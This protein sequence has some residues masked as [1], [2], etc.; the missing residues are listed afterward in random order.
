[1][2][3]R[4]G[5]KDLILYVFVTLLLILVL[6]AM[7]QFDR[8]FKEVQEIKR[9]NNDLTRDIV[10]IQRKLESGIITSGSAGAAEQAPEKLATFAPL[11]AAQAMSGYAP[12]DWLI[13]NFGTK[14]GR[15]T[16]LVASDLYQQ[17]VE[18][19]V[20][21]SLLVRSA[22]DLEFQPLL[23]T[24][25]EVKDNTEQWKKY[26]QPLKAKGLAPDKISEEVRK[27][28]K[29]PLA[30]EI[31]FKLRRG[32]QFSDGTP[33]TSD[34]VVFTFE[35]IMNEA[36][37]A[38]RAR[39]Y[40]GGLKK[41]EALGPYEVTFKFADPYFQL[42]DLIGSTAIMSKKFY[43]RFTP[44]QFNDHIGLMIGTG[45]YKLQNPESWN[46]G[47]GVELVRNERYWGVP[48]ALDRLIWR[49]I[50]DESAEMVMLG[51]GEL[52]I[53]AC[54]PEQY[55]KLL[56]DQRVMKMARPFKYENPLGGYTYI[57]WNQRKKI[58]EGK[59]VATP[60]A[61]KR[62]RQAMT[63]LVDRE[64]IVKDVYLGYART[65]SGPFN[66]DTPQA[67][68]SIKPWP[69]DETKAK[70]VL[71]ELGFKDKNND[72]VLE[73]PDGKPFSFKLSFPSGS[74]TTQRVVLFL[75]DSFARA[76]I[77]LEPDPL[78]WPVLLDRLKQS[79]F[80]ACMLGWGGVIE[81]DP[82]QIFH[83]SQIAGQ[84]DNRT[85]Y[86]NPDLDKAIEEAR[87]TL[88]DDERMKLWHKVHQILH[89]DQPYTYLHNR[90]ALVF[91][92]GR[93]QNVEKSK[94]GLNYVRLMPNPIPWFVPKPQ[95]RYTR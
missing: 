87:Q 78:D 83:S 18:S 63:M 53:L 32:V 8:Q 13:D 38:P 79:R 12:G 29:A 67:D 14:L 39:S 45:P 31:S 89:E 6:L 56:K 7:K 71:A 80:D 88:N 4:F 49:E 41:V 74:A 26:V 73:G 55:E 76:G 1:M 58:D 16:P 75:K 9:Q 20:M 3:N 68:P 82:Y 30:M 11:V 48:P 24:S 59:E 5:V 77:V 47:K 86:S 25:W 17:W 36:V 85:H 15:V 23:A 37:N 40:F 62:V 61:D 27:D 93:F 69:F 66:P 2:E 50:E 21:D 64:R 35:W 81:T 28:P 43:S 22:A 84:A 34:D 19:K 92:N 91:I 90:T 94:L 52:D 54:L 60:F 72:G 46:P 33:F 65:A 70:S 42:L 57:G 95:Q 44:Q 51:N 10:A